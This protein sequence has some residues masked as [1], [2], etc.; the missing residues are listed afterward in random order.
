MKLPKVDIKHILYATDLS[1]D[2]KYAFKYAAHFAKKFNAKLTLL[3]VIQEF[4]DLLI[5]DVGIERS[6][7]TEKRLSMNKAYLEDAKKKFIE[8]TKSELPSEEIAIEDIV[9]EK[10][11]P[12]K[13]ILRVTEDRNCDLIVMGIRGRGTLPDAMMGDTVGAVLR[14][15]KVPVLVLRQPKEKRKK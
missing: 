7:A 2:A 4:P 15:S 14:R 8:I 11:N 13:M 9:V 1:V 3:H 12:V 5:F 6:G 10:G